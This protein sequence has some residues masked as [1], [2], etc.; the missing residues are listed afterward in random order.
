MNL[1][2]LLLP[3]IVALAMVSCA[4]TLSP[5]N[6][7][8]SADIEEG[9]VMREYYVQ[10]G[11]TATKTLFDGKTPVWE[12]GETVS[13]YDPV[14]S[15]ARLFTVT[16]VDGRHAKIS[17]S[18]SEGDFP[19]S[20]V[21]PASC[22]K[23]WTD[24]EHCTISIP[25]EQSIPAGKNMASEAMASRAYSEDGNIVFENKV[26][27]LQFKIGR[28]D[29]RSVTFTLSGSEKKTYT[30]TGSGSD[31]EEGSVFYAAVDPGEYTSG[32][33]VSCT[34][35]Y[36]ISFNKT[37][38]KTVSA[39]L[40]GILNL[41]VVSDGSRHVN[42]TVTKE[43]YFS[44]FYAYLKA[45]GVESDL[46]ENEIIKAIIKSKVPAAN[47]KGRLIY[48]THKSAGPQGEPVT[49]SGVITVPDRA[50][51]SRTATN[52]FLIA[53]H[54]SIAANSQCPSNSLQYEAALAWTNYAVVMSDY[55]GFGASS[56][57]PQAY[58]HPE[59]TG[60][61]SV[62]AY[63]AAR[64]ILS[65]MGAEIGPKILNVG[66]SQG[67]ASA[68]ANVKYHSE[69]QKE[70]N[71]NFTTTFA[72]GAPY[73]AKSTWNE[74]LTG[75]CEDTVSYA[76]L[77]IVSFIEIEKLNVKYSDVFQEPLLSNY[78]EWILSKKYTTG[79]I[80]RKIGTT[81]IKKILAPDFLEKKNS[82]FNQIMAVAQKYSLSS[83]SWKPADNSVIYMHH[84]SE[85]DLVPFSNLEAIRNHFNSQSAS[86]IYQYIDLKDVYD[87]MPW[88]YKQLLKKLVG[89]DDITID[90]YYGAG[91]WG[92]DLIVNIGL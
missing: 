34:T 12:V 71:F 41:G 80:M 62:D 5:E 42:Y 21:Y 15:K 89:K 40:N 19:F 18:I 65:D 24:I 86:G 16:E 13:V 87:D 6:P 48:F 29:I 3:L 1:R 92:Y 7:E 46:L 9:L 35:Q 72:G 47:A 54:Y 30:V 66:Y 90:H 49:L 76:L 20:A 27:L 52:G 82:A 22:A 88:I 83:G 43:E 38:R 31:L 69:H 51:T 39:K 73:D 28:N 32:I 70:L 67:G 53:N 64:Q 36:D 33:Q 26:S 68:M 14:A 81:D 58:L 50:I 61:G 2:R 56:Q 11:T 55:Y 17:G 25:E 10:T 74:F 60:R 23:S 8:K 85:D 63:Q 37:S 75:K 77:S 44:D 4:K 45:L 59:V 57:Y 84:S 79:Q 91:F 78:K